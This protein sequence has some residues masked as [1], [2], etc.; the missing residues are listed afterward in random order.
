MLAVISNQRSIKE[1]GGSRRNENR[2]FLPAQLRS[3]NKV[4]LLR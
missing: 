4:L 2:A 3:K 1:E